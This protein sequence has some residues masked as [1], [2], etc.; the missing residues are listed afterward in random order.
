M[1]FILENIYIWFLIYV[2]YISI[3]VIYRGLFC[4]ALALMCGS[5]GVWGATLFVKKIY[6]NVKID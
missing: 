6:R 3:F 5:I 1:I 4:A 2:I